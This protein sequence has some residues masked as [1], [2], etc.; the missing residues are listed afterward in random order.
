MF[1]ALVHIDKRGD[2]CWESTGALCFA[3]DGIASPAAAT[4]IAA[5]G[6]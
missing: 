3:G 6:D 4:A 1:T 5:P 2:G